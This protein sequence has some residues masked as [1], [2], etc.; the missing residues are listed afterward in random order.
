MKF[1][2]LFFIIIFSSNLFSKQSNFKFSNK[3]DQ[4][5]IKFRKKTDKEILSKKFF[6]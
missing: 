4:I 1:F 5:I 6:L 3:T 2:Y